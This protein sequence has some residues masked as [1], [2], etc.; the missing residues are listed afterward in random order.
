[1]QEINTICKEIQSEAVYR[2]SKN[3]AKEVRKWT[4]TQWA[5][6]IE[7]IQTKHSKN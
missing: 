2:E 1:M 3:I 6:N 5:I 7:Y 4:S